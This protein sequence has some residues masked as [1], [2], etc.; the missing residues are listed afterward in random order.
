MGGRKKKKHKKK[1][2][3][4]WY[5]NNN[6]FISDSFSLFP[7]VSIGLHVTLHAF[8]FSYLHI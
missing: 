2:M 6:S 8:I 4:V 1:Q 7:L 5:M 3:L